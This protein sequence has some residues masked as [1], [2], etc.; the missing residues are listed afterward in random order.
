MQYICHLHQPLFLPPLQS[1][2]ALRAW[3]SQAGHRRDEQM[4]SFHVSRILFPWQRNLESV[5]R[6]KL[7]EALLP[8]SLPKSVL[9]EAFSL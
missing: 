1:E 6:A 3:C 8:K 2:V 7:R 5:D 9:P 4:E